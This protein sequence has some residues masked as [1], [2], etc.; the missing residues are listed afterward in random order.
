VVGDLLTP[1]KDLLARLVKSIP[2]NPGSAGGDGTA[3]EENCAAGATGQCKKKNKNL[4]KL[5]KA[6]TL[7][8]F[9]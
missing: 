1:L 3:R 5:L 9:T 8:C 4:F 7:L 2:H 6:N